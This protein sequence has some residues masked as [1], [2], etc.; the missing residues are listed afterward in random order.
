MK[1]SKLWY[2][3]N[4]FWP[5]NIPLCDEYLSLQTTGKVFTTFNKT[6]RISMYQQII[7]L[8]S[9][10]SSLEFFLHLLIMRIMLVRFI[11]NYISWSRYE[12]N[13]SSFLPS[14]SFLETPLFWVSSRFHR[15]H[16]HW[17]LNLPSIL[18]LYSLVS[19][20]RL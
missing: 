1:T 16:N 19:S 7:F 14:Y 20:C 2:H 12:R 8:I 5:Y 3:H 11:V 6:L 17:Y 4:I 13:T 10:Q 15:L 9:I 18:S